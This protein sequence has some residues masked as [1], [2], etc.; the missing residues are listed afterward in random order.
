MNSLN[1]SGTH[2]CHS[3]HRLALG[4]LRPEGEP[5]LVGVSHSREHELVDGSLFDHLN[6]AQ[7]WNLS[8]VNTK[9]KTNISWQSRLKDE[10][11]TKN[12]PSL[13]DISRMHSRHDNPPLRYLHSI[14]QP[15]SVHLLV[16]EHHT[17]LCRG[18][19][20]TLS[21]WHA[22][23]HWG[24]TL[25]RHT[26]KHSLYRPSHSVYMNVLIIVEHVVTW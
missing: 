22:A 25:W 19:G 2:T 26:N 3:E 10:T 11:L 23:L 20:G 14:L 24:K 8:N 9:D 15:H 6:P 21:V 1:R 4:P 17:E 12:F 16:I 7:L 18:A 13:I 5:A